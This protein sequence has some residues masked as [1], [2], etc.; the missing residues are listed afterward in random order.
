MMHSTR[1]ESRQ[2]TARMIS[3]RHKT[4]RISPPGHKHSAA[5]RPLTSQAGSSPPP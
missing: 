4:T 5:V 2:A 3:A 1:C